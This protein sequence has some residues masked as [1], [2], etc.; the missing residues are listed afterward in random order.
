MG[1]HSTGELR[2]LVKPGE[3][4]HPYGAE[5]GELKGKPSLNLL[6]AGTLPGQLIHGTY[7]R[8]GIITNNY[9]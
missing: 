1:L 6:L 8:V 4:G 3:A 5:A 2:L 9:V 7:M